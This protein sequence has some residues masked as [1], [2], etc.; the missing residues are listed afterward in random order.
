MRLLAL[1]VMF[2]AWPALGQ[3]FNGL[4]QSQ[5]DDL[6]A[7]QQLAQQRLIAQANELRALESRVRAEQAVADQQAARI[8]FRLPEPL[9]GAPPRTIDVDQLPSIPDE[10]LAASNRRIRETAKNPR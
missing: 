7:Q 6:R 3:D 10:A 9:P 2:A 8:P 5:L 1:L 4:N